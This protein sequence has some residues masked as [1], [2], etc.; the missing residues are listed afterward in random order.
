MPV[1]HQEIQLHAG[2]QSLVQPADNSVCFILN[3]TLVLSLLCRHFIF[4]VGKNRNV[5]ISVKGR[6][7]GCKLHL[8]ANNTLA[9]NLQEIKL[10]T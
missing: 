8:S 9:G 10:G 4:I 2:A 3:T 1:P 7:Q 5:C 6:A